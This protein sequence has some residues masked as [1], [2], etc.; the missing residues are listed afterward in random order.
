MIQKLFGE[1][2]EEQYRYLKSRFKAFGVGL[3]MMAI[4]I[5]LGFIG[6]EFGRIF[7]EVGIAFCAIM[8]L[9]FGW[10]IMRGLFGIA[11]V[12]ALFS[13]NVVFGCA[14]FV[15]YLVI[16]YL[17]GIIVAIIGLCR[18]LVLSKKKKER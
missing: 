15:L 8:F 7:Y 17:G 5:L 10:A 13:G 14:I 11:T 9:V 4:G 2:E 16:G 3:A 1:T 12:G 18:F 6:I